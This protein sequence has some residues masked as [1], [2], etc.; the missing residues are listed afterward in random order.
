MV[1]VIGLT[2]GIGSGKSTVSDYFSE[3]GVPVIDAD[4][5]AKKLCDAKN[6]GFEKIRE[7]FGETILDSDG[8]ISR[9]KLRKIIFENSTERCWLENYLH[10]LIIEAILNWVKQ[11]N[12]DYCIVVAPLLFETDLKNYVNRVLVIEASKEVKI[13]RVISRDKM[14]QEE[15][16]KILSNQ[17]SSEERL[18][19]ADDIILNEGGFEELREKVLKM[20]LFYVGLANTFAEWN[21]SS[22]DEAYNDL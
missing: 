11:V 3:L 7:R 21:S 18:A 12:S 8:E 4:D 5:V 19:M 6:I 9:K 16:E 20:N 2:G 13:K 1:F 22:D 14:H 15:I 10:P 17:L